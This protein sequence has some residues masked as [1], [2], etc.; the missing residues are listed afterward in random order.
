MASSTMRS[1][2]WSPPGA[3]PQVWAALVED[4][5]AAVMVVD[6]EGTIEYANSCA[7]TTLTGT[8]G[9]SLIGRRLGDFFDEEYTRERM[10]I[11][12]DVMAS[13][14]SIALEGMSRGRNVRSVFRALQG[15]GDHVL[16]VSRPA[17]PGVEFGGGEPGR[18]VVRARV[19]DSGKLGN[20]TLREME[21]L[22]LI[23]MGLSTADIAKKLHRSVK[24]I[25]W[26]RVSLG[27]KL[28][29][30]NRVELARIAIGAGLV[31]VDMPCETPGGGASGAST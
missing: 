25:E 28:G 24:T 12:G 9:Q 29:V 19:N 16:I 22:K 31:G 11:V 14:R 20:L 2:A 3:D 18:N 8:P 13:R 6:R 4:T 27:E 7:A 5:Q 23:G 15:D 26:H 30:T 21:I 17:N 10:E 1:G